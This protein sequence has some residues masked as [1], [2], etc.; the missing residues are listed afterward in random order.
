MTSPHARSLPPLT[1]LPAPP[2]LPQEETHLVAPGE[3]LVDSRREILRRLLRRLWAPALVLLGLWY[4]LLTL[5]VAGASPT[6]WFFSLL[7]G[8]G[9]P[10]YVRQA[11]SA[12][13][14]TSEGLWTAFLLLPVGATVLSLLG[15]LLVPR[16]VAPLQPRR[17]LGEAQFQRAVADRTTAPLMALPV[18]VVLVLPLSVVLGMPQP[19]SGLG[20][21]PLSVWCAGL[22]ALELG[23]ILVRRCV[24][25]ARILGV[26]PHESIHTEARIGSD[27]EK[28]RAAARRHLA[29]D[30]RHLPPN[31]GTPAAGGARSPRGA[32]LALALIAR[33]SLTWVLPALAGLGWLVFGIADLVT[34][35]TSL[36]SMDLSQVSTPLSWQHLVVGIPLSVLVALGCAL[37]PAVATALS[38][39]QRGEVRDQRTYPEWAHRARVNPWEARVCALTGWLCAGWLLAATVLA[40]I[41]LPLLSAGTALT[42]TFLVALALMA[43]PLLGVGAARAMRAGLRDVLYGPPGD[44]MRRE[45]PFALVAPEFGTRADR[46]KDP[47]VRAALRRRL[48][49]DG[50]DHALEIFDLDAS[51]ER[52]WVD[53]SAPGASDTAVREADLERGVLPDFGGEGSAFTG[54]G[55]D[56]SEQ[57]ASLHDIPESVT[58]LRERR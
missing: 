25:A 9:D 22:L 8:L 16:L 54:G 50:G 5:Y 21:G 2:R 44:Y 24:P 56:G 34:V 58:G 38:A 6:F 18:L 30:R 1:D 42:W 31:P 7:A 20:A 48:Q 17:F 32:L 19:W 43:T 51:G 29:Q 46:A 36:A 52:L 47:A 55:T 35:L 53:D 11:Q 37:A 23:W 4:A 26:E 39:G 10:A 49:A 28:R 27:P 12:L 33:A 57:A 45:V 41:A 15:A 13:G 40:A 14:F 3:I